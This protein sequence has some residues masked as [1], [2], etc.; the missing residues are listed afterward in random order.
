MTNRRG[1]TDRAT[2]SVSGAISNT[3][4]SRA[5]AAIAR[6]ASAAS[7][8]G[9]PLVRITSVRNES[10]FCDCGRY[11]CSVGAAA[12]LLL[13]HVADDADDGAPGTGVAADLH[14]LAD[15]IGA[16]PQRAS[17]LLAD[18]H[19]VLGAGADRRR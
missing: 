6:R 17:G 2:R 9:S 15:R 8:A 12:R 16:G 7:C 11:I 14:V 13:P 4:T 18:E 10:V 5:S 1:P 19:D 3:G